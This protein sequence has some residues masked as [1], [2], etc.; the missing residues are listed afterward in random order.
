[1]KI[2]VLNGS[3]HTNGNTSA[4][5]KEFTEGAQANGNEV[6]VLQAGTMKIGGCL[7]CEYC[8]SHGGT[9]IQKDDMAQIYEALK[10]A[11]MLVIASPIYYFTLTGQM[12]CAIHRTYAVGIPETLRVSALLLSSGSDH[13]YD[14]AIKQ[15][16][17]VFQDY[18]KLHDAGIITA[19]GAE[20][21]SMDKLAEVRAFGMSV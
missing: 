19:Y 8:H 6:K 11:E 3:P 14:A 5:V 9:C 20:N 15:Y 1:M 13:V 16:H 4:L 21:G 17:I 2:L 10:D 12:Q 7:G 18:M